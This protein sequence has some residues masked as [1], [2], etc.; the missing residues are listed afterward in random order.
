M[1]GNGA[2]YPQGDRTHKGTVN[3]GDKVVELFEIK[4]TDG[5]IQVLIQG[6][7]NC[8]TNWTALTR[9]GYD[10]YLF[11]LLIRSLDDFTTR[12]Q[13][14]DLAHAA[15]LSKELSVSLITVFKDKLTVSTKLE[16]YIDST[17][18]RLARIIQTESEKAFL[19]HQTTTSVQ[20]PK[21]YYLSARNEDVDHCRQH[22]LAGGF[23]VK[24]FYHF[25]MLLRE[26]LQHPADH[27]LVDLEALNDVG[28]GEL[29]GVRSQRES[30]FTLTLIGG[31][32]D[33]ETRIQAAQMSADNLLCGVIDAVDL[34]K[35]FYQ[36]EC[37]IH[38]AFNPIL[39][40]SLKNKAL[41]QFKSAAS[42]LKIDLVCAD[43]I[44]DLFA[45]GERI[46]P[47][48]IV[49]SIE[50]YES[51][52][53]ELVRRLQMEPVLNETPV[54]ISAGLTQDRYHLPL[55]KLG[56]SD[57]L[58]NTLTPSWILQIASARKVF[59]DTRIREEEI[60]S[61][62]DLESGVVTEGRFMQLLQYS[63]KARDHNE[64][65]KEDWAALIHLTHYIDTRE[66]QD[67]EQKALIEAN[68]ALRKHIVSAL[69]DELG[70]KDLLGGIGTED[71]CI[72]TYRDTEDS[73]IAFL[74]D[75]RNKIKLLSNQ[76]FGS[77]NVIKA[78]FGAVRLTSNDNQQLLA[79]AKEMTARASNGGVS[80]YAL[81]TISVNK[82]QPIEP[83]A[84]VASHTSLSELRAAINDQRLSLVYQP[85][86][87]K[88]GGTD[89]YEVF[90]RVMDVNKNWMQTSEVIDTAKTYGLTRFLDRWV[91][92][93]VLSEYASNRLNG[94]NHKSLFIKVTRESFSDHKFVGWVEKQL[95]IKNINAKF[96]CLQISMDDMKLALDN[97]KRFMSQCHSIGLS[98]S[99]ERFKGDQESMS[100]VESLA[101]AFDYLKLDA[102]Y[103]ERLSWDARARH[104]FIDVRGF[105]GRNQ[106]QVV[107]PFVESEYTLKMFNRMG[108]ELM[109]GYFIQRP[110]DQS[111]IVTNAS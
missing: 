78:Y 29:I 100:I 97:A 108:I 2:R 30:Q 71:L 37:A 21:I 46:K 103:I 94:V 98:V 58:M 61:Y 60:A 80:D 102:D 87:S 89:K 72:V 22:L 79:E 28:K 51:S 111:Q 107:A 11:K 101:T 5:A 26:Q 68:G 91:V 55:V 54:I 77:K 35:V 18:D 90:L 44:A 84:I 32:D 40:F 27:W 13:E 36:H 43:T 106:I 47:S 41:D 1:L 92:N 95:A 6:L 31:E 10:R 52:P 45:K 3:M 74:E 96:I 70:R 99:L 57:F 81:N 104:K 76:L 16:E 67:D 105:C 42:K 69:V 8:V 38:Q 62:I 85:I 23:D 110:Q 73:L 82:A 4:D 56:V 48:A 25:P 64:L 19:K 7:K 53:T 9:S 33:E 83:E 39:V 50:G 65:D 34:V 17:F 66:I 86:V 88:S 93:E 75:I 24:T 59:S 109:Q 49:L 20:K 12:N 63:L 14:A 15:A